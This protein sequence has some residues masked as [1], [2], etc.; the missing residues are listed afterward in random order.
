MSK[1]QT[2]MEFKENEKDKTS[3][4]K[5]AK[6]ETVGKDK[7][8]EKKEVVKEIPKE[9]PKDQ[10]KKEKRAEDDANKPN[11]PSGMDVIVKEDDKKTKM[12]DGYEDF[13]PG[14]QQS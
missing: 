10:P 2:S 6:E 3:D 5:K 14:A 8:K 4:N 13:G 12:D 11:E 7:K 9:Q 1:S